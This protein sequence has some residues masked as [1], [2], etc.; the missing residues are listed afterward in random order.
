MN[1]EHLL[2]TLQ[3]RLG[4]CGWSTEVEDAY[5]E[6]AHLVCESGN[7]PL[8]VF[9]RLELVLLLLAESAEDFDLVCIFCADPTRIGTTRQAFGRL[10]RRDDY[11]IFRTVCDSLFLPLG[12]V[13]GEPGIRTRMKS[14]TRY[15]FGSNEPVSPAF[16]VELTYNCSINAKECGTDYHHSRSGF[17]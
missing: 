1:I 8:N 11:A 3:N 6:F 10:L 13:M 9:T 2:V 12:W 14:R 4:E 15:R 5:P 16:E 7:G 17:S